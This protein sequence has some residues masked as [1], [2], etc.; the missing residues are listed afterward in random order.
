[1]HVHMVMTYIIILF[2]ISMN[3]L[4]YVL[5]RKFDQTKISEKSSTAL[6]HFSLQI[7]KR[8]NFE[9]VIRNTSKLLIRLMDTNMLPSMRPLYMETIVNVAPKRATYKC[10]WVLEL[11][12]WLSHWR[13]H[14]PLWYLHSSFKL[15]STKINPDAQCISLLIR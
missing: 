3:R 7:Q 6:I 11:N 1:M 10:P 12:Q 9:L 8:L 4:S 13:I 2:A 5:F 14:W 15:S